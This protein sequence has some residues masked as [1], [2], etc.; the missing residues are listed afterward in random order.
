MSQN[1]TI[2]NGYQPAVFDSYLEKY[3]YLIKPTEYKPCP[4]LKRHKIRDDSKFDQTI[5][6]VDKILR[7]RMD[8]A[9]FDYSQYKSSDKYDQD[10]S[11]NTLDQCN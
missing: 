1:T 10:F 8:E 7:K 6:L 3:N 9:G 4:G 11:F 5:S 2:E